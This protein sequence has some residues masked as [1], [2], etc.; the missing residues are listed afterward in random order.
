PFPYLLATGLKDTPLVGGA[1]VT[2]LAIPDH[3]LVLVAISYTV[4]TS[5]GVFS[6]LTMEHGW[7]I[8]ESLRAL[9]HAKSSRT[10][11]LRIGR[12]LGVLIIVILLVFQGWQ[13]L[14]GSFYPSGYIW[15]GTGNGLSS[16]GT[17][18]PSSPPPEMYHVY[19]WLLSQSGNFNVYWPGASG[20]SYPWSEKATGA[21]AYFNSPRPTIYP[22]ALPYLLQSNLTG[23][24]SD[25]L[26]AL[27][28]R[29]LVVQP[30]DKVAME[31]SWGV[32][33]PFNLNRILERTPGI[34]F[35]FS[36]GEISVYELDGSWGSIYSAPLLASHN[37]TDLE[38][39]IAYHVFASLGTK[40]A[41]V[42][43]STPAQSLCF[44]DLYC[45]IAILSPQYVGFQGSTA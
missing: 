6:I 14:S 30:F 38:Y 25:Y 24:I 5:L 23:D 37:S 40:I 42:D 45:P 19:D 13:F 31:Y 4:L 10:P 3:A 43:P 7:R 17:F 16:V 22:P 44:D 1:L 11:N 35:L 8:G 15:D 32:S 21:L 26:S 2:F 28:I 12:T 29:Y 39:A 20:A 18:T 36:D 33:D 27:N 41:L 9:L 34:S